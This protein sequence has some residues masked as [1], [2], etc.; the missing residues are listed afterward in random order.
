MSLILKIIFLKSNT[1]KRPIKRRHY[2][3][4]FHE[5]GLPRMLG[6]L[7]AI[8]WSNAQ[9]HNTSGKSTGVRPSIQGIAD[10]FWQ[11]KEKHFINVETAKKFRNDG[12]SEHKNGQKIPK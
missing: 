1:L 6:A 5:L 9:R 12:A 3:N 10:I 4:A 11:R 2:G 7:S 8:P